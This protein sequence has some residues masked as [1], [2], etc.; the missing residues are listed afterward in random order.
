MNAAQAARRLIVL[1]IGIAGAVWF[2]TSRRPLQHPPGVLTAGDPEQIAL[3]A[4]LPSIEK[5]GWTLRPLA[6][7][8]ITARVLAT[9]HYSWDATAKIAPYDLA[10]GWGPMSN[11]AVLERLDVSQSGRYY[12]WRYWGRPPIPEKEII[13]HSA[14][15]HLIPADDSTARAIS[16]LRVGSLVKISGYLVEATHPQADHAWRSSLT[17]DDEGEGACEII[18]VKSLVELQ[19]AR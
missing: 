5:E 16:S 4:L 2:N 12:H 10:L 17:R 3:S 6:H 14:N 8:F 15:T 9:E 13:T 1:G 19:T 7:Y 18:Y 11:T